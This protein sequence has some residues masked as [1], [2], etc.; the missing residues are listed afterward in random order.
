MMENRPLPEINDANRP[1][2]DAA[3]RGELLLPRCN[4]CAK[5]FIPPRAWCPHCFAKDI[6]WATASGRGTVASF[7]KLHIAPFEGYVSTFPYVL[8][9]VKLAEGPQLMANIVNCDPDLVR[10]GSIVS[11]TFET[12][13]EGVVVP[14]FELA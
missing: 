3:R 4:A 1:Y 7:S 6:G 2:W 9:T 13:A 11:V 14:Q 8:A 12:R 10:V 5:F